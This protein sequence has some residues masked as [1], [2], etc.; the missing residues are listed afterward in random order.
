V[1]RVWQVVSRQPIL[2][3]LAAVVVAFSI[4][5]GS[6]FL[7]GGNLTNVS[8][9]VAFDGLATVGQTICLI[10]GGMDISVG[11]VMAMATALAIG[12][13][14]AGGVPLGVA[15]ALIF[16]LAIGSVNGLLV[17]VARINPFIAT[18]GTM[19]A[20]RGVLL[21][22]TGAR[23][24]AGTV[25]AFAQ[26]GSGVI[27][28]VPVPTAVFV[29]ALG[30]AWMVMGRTRFGRNVYTVGASVEAARLAGIRTGH[31]QFATYVICGFTASL[32]GVLLAARLNAAS[33]H[34]GSDTGLLTIAGAVMG[35][36]S[37]FGGRGSVVGGALGI[38]ALGLLGNGMDLVGLDTYTQ[39]ATRAALIIAVVAIGS[40][41]S[42]RAARERLQAVWAG[43]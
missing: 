15:A 36:T 38:L 31:V 43:R 3:M 41:V 39:T 20:V 1:P 28:F 21:L 14:P 26:F 12:L 27:G 40:F 11:A 30:L 23:P 13:Q 16:G 29:V 18:L 5:R 4:T 24:I 17:V 25:P 42:S 19:V 6:V 33:I 35:G 9:Q 10:G 34:L 22:Y 8:R 32:A 37:I 2:I 7:S